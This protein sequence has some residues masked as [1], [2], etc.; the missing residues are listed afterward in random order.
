MYGNTLTH[1]TCNAINTAF[2]TKL[3]NGV[4]YCLLLQE[5]RKWFVLKR[6]G[7][8]YQ[9]DIYKD[10]KAASK[11]EA[12]KGCIKMEQVVEVQRT[13]DKKQTFE[14]LCPGVGYKFT[15][16][17]EA[18]ADDWV[19][20]LRKLKSY[21]KEKLHPDPITI[22]HQ[23]QSCPSIEHPNKI[24]SPLHGIHGISD[25]SPRSPSHMQG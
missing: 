7:R 25:H 24:V 10:E 4:T 18:E 1:V 13:T 8:E 2:G 11:G 3:R 20:I 22:L 9:L 12:T 19:N 6:E 23:S 5:K 16:N 14:I 17:S 21:R 15:A